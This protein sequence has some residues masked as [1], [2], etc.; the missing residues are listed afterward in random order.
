VEFIPLYYL[1]A[2]DGIVLLVRIKRHPGKNVVFPWDASAH[3]R[4][5]LNQAP[6]GGSHPIAAL[7]Q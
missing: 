5:N 1:I 3:S 2:D 7:N 6:L 4:S